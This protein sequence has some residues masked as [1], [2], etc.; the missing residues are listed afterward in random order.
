MPAKKKVKTKPQKIKLFI[1]SRYYN[2]L[3]KVLG[4]EWMCNITTL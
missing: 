2:E 1:I 3:T 4:K